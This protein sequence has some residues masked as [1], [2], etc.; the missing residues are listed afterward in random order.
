[1][2]H[3][4]YFFSARLPSSRRW[5]AFCFTDELRLAAR[6]LFD[7]GVAGLTDEETISLVDKWQNS[8]KR[9]VALLR[10]TM[11]ADVGL[12]YLFYFQTQKEGLPSL[13]RLCFSADSLPLT[14][15]VCSPRGWRFPLLEV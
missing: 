2:S 13:Q 7:A 4:C 14:N 12:Q 6:T 1:M 15:T 5:R 3:L 11:T 9:F 10:R 8:R